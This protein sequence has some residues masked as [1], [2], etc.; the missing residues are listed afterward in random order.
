MRKLSKRKLNKIQKYISK[1]IF[2]TTPLVEFNHYKGNFT[3]KN[4]DTV[5]TIL[6]FVISFLPVYAFLFFFSDMKNFTS[7]F[8]LLMFFAFISEYYFYKF[9]DK[10]KELYFK[11]TSYKLNK[12]LNILENIPIKENDTIEIIQIKLNTPQIFDC[13]KEITDNKL[14]DALYQR[15]NHDKYHCISS[16]IGED[17]DSTNDF[18]GKIQT[19]VSYLMTE[20]RETQIAFF[21]FLKMEELRLELINK[22]LKELTENNYSIEEAVQKDLITEEVYN[23]LFQPLFIELELL[24]QNCLFKKE[25]TKQLSQLVKDNEMKLKI[26]TVMETIECLK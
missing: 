4:S 19:A 20:N 16:F 9:F 26:H 1:K 7:L 13:F 2:W 15:F 8:F 10:W 24:I 21:S 11:F 17:S 23:K 6:S 5:P 3:V 18:G 22:V 12:Y 14:L 25:Q